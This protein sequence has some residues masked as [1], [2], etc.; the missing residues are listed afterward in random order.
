M[1]RRHR[2]VTK[3]TFNTSKASMPSSKL[4]DHDLVSTSSPKLTPLTNKQKEYLNAIKVYEMI[5]SVGPAG[6]GKTY[7][8][9]V[10][11]A[12]LLK[13]KKIKQIILTRPNVPTGRSLGFFPGTL[14]EKMAPWTAPI[15]AVFKDVLGQGMLETAVKNEKIVILP[16][17]TIRGW[18]FQDCFVILDEAQNTTVE[19]IKA[20]VTRQG[21]RCTTIINGD[22]SQTDIK[23][24]SGLKYL[25]EIVKKSEALTK[26][27]P[28]VEFTE[29]DI[30]RSG[31]CRE[32][33][34]AFK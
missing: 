12:N 29:D 8:P 24:G 31:L 28:I 13:D 11:A 10:T 6:T 16:L 3:N 14:E 27:V 22:I 19:E 15:M 1:G 20:F 23:D 30:V 32:F 9:S 18:T 7:V 34:K 2:E 4:L 25:L 17:E 33:V 21:E 26:A 5:I